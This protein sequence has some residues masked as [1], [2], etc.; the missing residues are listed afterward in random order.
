M[1]LILVLLAGVA[2]GQSCLAADPTPPPAPPAAAAP[3]PAPAPGID[4]AAKHAKVTACRDQA[5]AK[6]L[7]GAE[8]KDFIAR[9]TAA[10]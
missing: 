5:R 9:C 8:K 7:L 3:A 1:R 6:K 2:T 10:P 4:H